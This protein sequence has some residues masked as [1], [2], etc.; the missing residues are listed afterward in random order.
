MRK[1]RGFVIVAQ[2][3]LGSVSPELGQQPRVNVISW[4]GASI[5]AGIMDD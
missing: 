4:H 3:T 1:D 2:N 5:R